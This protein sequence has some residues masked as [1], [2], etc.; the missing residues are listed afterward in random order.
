MKS[1]F[2]KMFLPLIMIV[3]FMVTGCKEGNPPSD[4]PTHTVIVCGSHANTAYTSFLNT[5]EVKSTV[6]ES[7]ES[8]FGSVTLI[9][10]DGQPFVAEKF[11][12]NG[13]E[14]KLSNKKKT[15]IASQQ[16]DQILATAKEIKTVTPEVDL[17]SALQLADRSLSGVDGKKQ[18]IVIDS[19]LST[20]G[21]VNFFN[22]K[23][24]EEIGM[25]KQL[26]KFLDEEKEL[27][28]LDGVDV[29]WIGLGDTAGQ[30]EACPAAVRDTLKKVWETVLTGA[31]SVTFSSAVPGNEPERDLPSVSVVEYP[32]DKVFEP[33]V[34]DNK[35]L[36]FQADSTE[37]ADISAAKAV[38]LP[39][40]NELKD[41]RIQIAIFGTTASVGSNTSCIA[42]SEARA[43]T[44]KDILV[45][46][47][48]PEEQIA[49]VKGLGYNNIF[50]T[51]D[52]LPNGTL[53]PLKAER[54]RSVIVMSI[55][56]ARKNNL[57]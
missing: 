30:Q 27:P 14:K 21:K 47:G 50:H 55:D 24:L 23:L 7:T 28:G 53:D 29:L 33:V 12:I 43:Q 11:Q 46:M 37:L 20:A 26:Y 6:M 10:S 36:M 44:A 8:S 4:T 9:V 25:E 38:L 31:K 16:A 19:G 57:I 41:N 2:K 54:N 15:Q 34:F 56:D 1:K 35:T 17:L 51:D 18:I 42:F 13:S 49:Y 32:E 48:L 52:R 39:M 5:E 3:L 22:S 40:V 45:E